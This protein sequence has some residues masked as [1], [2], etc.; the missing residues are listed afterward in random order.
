MEF[1]KYLIYNNSKTQKY[2]ILKVKILDIFFKTLI[3]MYDSG[4]MYRINI[5]TVLYSVVYYRHCVCIAY[6]ILV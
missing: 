4:N 1:F 2:V 6:F 5:D 3:E